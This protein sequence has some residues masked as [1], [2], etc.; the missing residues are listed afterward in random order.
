LRVIVSCIGKFHAFALAEQLQK[1]EILGGLYTSYA[2]QKNK[3]MRRF[4]GRL[5]KEVI[6]SKQIHTNI[7][8]AVLIK[9]IPKE[10][11]WIELFDRWVSHRLTTNNN[12]DVFIGWSGMSL[13]SIQTAKRNGKTTVLERGSSHIEYQNSILK[14][15]YAKNNQKFSIDS[16]VIEKELQEYDEC[17]FISIPSNFVKKTFISK[18]V[19]DE[20]L[21][22][23]PYGAASIFQKSGQVE[24]KSKF[25]ILYLGGLTRR[26]GLIY[27]FDALN[28]LGI[29][30]NQFE[31]WFIGNVGDEIKRDV[32]YSRKENWIFF[33]HK[34]QH[35]LPS[36]IS[37]C[38][39]AVQP[40][41]EEGLSMVIPQILG[42]G[43]PVIAT[44]NTGGENIIRDG[45]TG[46]IVPI[47]SPK[48]IAEKIQ[49]LY[50]NP[51]LLA[52]MKKNAADSVLSG[53]TWD[54]YGQRYV[55][56]LNQIAQR[57]QV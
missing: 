49:F 13:H 8:L 40:S 24:I 12:Y 38:D 51:K 53:F 5:D 11:L 46:F 4:A 19:K 22:V 56:F 57:S 45:E 26:K 36:L 17:D 42:C 31:V 52:T 16:R 43:I 28:N 35:E 48:A 37:K 54:D 7:P 14:E 39:I 2:W 34:A 15:E 23:N 18:G 3:I 33:G 6:T 21:I 1:H 47:R 44:T 41:I 10:Y 20:K 27:L 9:T 29:A 25:T 30:S 50:E 32:E 55:H